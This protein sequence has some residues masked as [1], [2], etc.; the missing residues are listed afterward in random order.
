TTLKVN[1]APNAVLRVKPDPPQGPGPLTV[2]FDMCGSS[3]SDGDPLSFFFNFGDGNKSSGSCIDTHT[4]A[5]SFREASTGKVSALDAS[6]TFEGSVVD[7]SG[8]SQTRTRTVIAQL[9]PPPT[10]SCPDPKVTINFP[11]PNACVGTPTFTA[12]ATASDSKSVSFSLDQVQCMYSYII[13]AS[14]VSS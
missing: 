9:T 4:Y 3:D 14:N 1:H 13:L 5:A 8:A 2:T 12:M 10:T 7:P 11:T 6:Y